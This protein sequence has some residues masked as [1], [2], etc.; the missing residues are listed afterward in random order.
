MAEIVVPEEVSANQYQPGTIVGGVASSTAE[1]YA[2]GVPPATKTVWAKVVCATKFKFWSYIPKPA[3]SEA[4]ADAE[5][6]TVIL[7]T[8]IVSDT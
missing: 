6:K 2:V 8:I 3:V 1:L 5:F 4:L 7:F